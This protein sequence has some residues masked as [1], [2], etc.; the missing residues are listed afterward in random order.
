M[1]ALHEC[2]N[3]QLRAWRG[4]P[5]R[6]GD[7]R[8]Y[9][10]GKGVFATRD[11]TDGERL[12]TVGGIDVTTLEG[13]SSGGCT[14]YTC[15]WSGL[16]RD[17]DPGR[18]PLPSQEVHAGIGQ[19]ANRAAGGGALRRRGRPPRVPPPVLPPEPRINATLCNS[20]ADACLRATR[21]I[22]AGEEVNIDCGATYTVRAPPAQGASASAKQR[23][24]GV[25]GDVAA[26]VQRRRNNHQVTSTP[27]VR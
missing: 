26:A 21:R 25:E 24:A 4:A 27:H 3:E 13:S 5:V 6:L 20:A 12:C 22:R 15:A 2:A 14:P 16:W 7:S 10:A 9:G 11:V 18:V 1:P 23:G 19:F 8:L 17:G